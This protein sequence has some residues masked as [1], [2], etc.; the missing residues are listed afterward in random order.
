[1][2]LKGVFWNRNECILR[3]LT[4]QRG[5]NTIIPNPKSKKSW[6]LSKS[7][8]EPLPVEWLSGCVEKLGRGGCQRFLHPFPFFSS[9]VSSD[10]FFLNLDLL[11]AFSLHLSAPDHPFLFR[12]G[13]FKIILLLVQ[14]FTRAL[15]QLRC[16]LERERETEGWIHLKRTAPLLIR[17]PW[18][19]HGG[20]PRYP[21]PP[22]SYSRGRK[23]P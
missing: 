11:Y 14:N 12:R 21:P 6:L 7:L 17:C 8:V 3:L 23:M 13:T 9:R 1:M 16:Y 4:F 20:W 15:T 10:S 19:G 18:R 2:D 22:L 5:S